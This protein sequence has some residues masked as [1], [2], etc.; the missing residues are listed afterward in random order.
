MIVVVDTNVVVSG[1]ITRD[2]QAAT[3]RILDGMLAARLRYLLSLDLLSE[4]RRVLLRPAIRG[5]HGLSELEVDILLERLVRQGVL[6]QPA[7]PAIEVVRGDE[8]L[9]ALLREL[10][11]AV[12]VTG[13]LELIRKAPEW[14]SV[15][16]PSDFLRWKG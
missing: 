10:P 9:F 16:T 8:H 7:Q 5:R 2:A 15:L 6:R 11:E 1:L 14:A 12:L 4:C 13:D 3:A